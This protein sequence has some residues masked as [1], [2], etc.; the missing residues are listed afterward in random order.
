M[1]GARIAAKAR[2]A[3]EKAGRKTGTGSP[4]T[5]TITRRTAAD[6]STYPP[7]PGQ[8]VKYRCT[9]FLSEYSARDRDGSNITERDLKAMIAVPVVNE[10]DETDTIEPTN[11]DTLQVAG[12]SYS[13]VSVT[14]YQPGGVVLYFE[15]QVRAP[16]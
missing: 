12:R 2:A 10:N 11:S 14:P 8:D 3:I 9:L 13:V 5:G 1:S 4:L 6:D 16:E 15:A 7:T